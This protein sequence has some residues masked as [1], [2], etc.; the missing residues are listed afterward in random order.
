MPPESTR[1]DDFV[2]SQPGGNDLAM[3]TLITVAGAGHQWPGAL[4]SPV[5]QRIGNL[6]PPSTALNATDTIWQFFIQKQR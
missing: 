2:S 4:P 6:P 5:A 3:I 1:G